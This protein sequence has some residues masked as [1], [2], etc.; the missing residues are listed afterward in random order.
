MIRRA[1]NLSKESHILAANIDL[2][3]LVVTIHY[4][5]TTTTFIDRFLATAEAYG[6]PALLVFNKTDR[7]DADELEYVEE[8]MTL[9]R[10]IK[11]GRRPARPR[12]LWNPPAAAACPGGR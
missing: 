6:I 9:Y 12:P 3:L 2:A 4:P 11:A 1:S 5:Q 10:T 8:L 7:Y